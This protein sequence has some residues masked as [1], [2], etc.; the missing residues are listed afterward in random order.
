[1]AATL[2]IEVV[3]ALPQQQTIAALRVDR[4]ATVLDALRLSGIFESHPELRIE[5]CEV[6]IWGRI[7]RPDTPLRDGDR[8]ELCRPLA[9]D[10][11]TARRRRAARARR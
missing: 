11:K 9:A 2:A 6:A 8:L 4:G 3:Y 1:M 5:R 7:A 10:P